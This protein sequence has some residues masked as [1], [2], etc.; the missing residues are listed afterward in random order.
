M[1]LKAG[2][3]VYQGPADG[4][5]QFFADVGYP[6]PGQP[7]QTPDTHKAA[8]GCAGTDAVIKARHAALCRGGKGD[9]ARACSAAAA[10]CEFAD[11]WSRP[12]PALITARAPGQPFAP[13]TPPPPAELT[14]PADH[15][16]DVMIGDQQQQ[17]PD[18]LSTSGDS[19][20]SLD[21]LSKSAIDLRYRLKQSVDITYGKDR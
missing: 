10:S 9:S 14:N 7:A 18:G 5:L 6:V 4:A 2:S 11:Q 16:M 20:T 21:L 1:L 19:I 15:F 17:Q 13:P 3:L 12:T 8:G